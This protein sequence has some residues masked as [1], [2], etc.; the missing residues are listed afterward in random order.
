MKKDTTFVM[1][2]Y[3]YHKL[4]S[5]YSRKFDFTFRTSDL[6]LSFTL[7]NS[8]LLPAFWTVVETVNFSLL[9]AADSILPA[10]HES[11]SKRQ[12][13][14]VLQRTFVEVL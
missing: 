5:A 13:L 14:L 12:I 11:V 8:N 10:P 6:H 9:E 7:W 3:P 1:S 4:F 2:E